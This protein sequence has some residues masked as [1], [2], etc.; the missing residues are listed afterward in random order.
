VE[1][2]RQTGNDQ[3]SL[4]YHHQFEFIDPS[5]LDLRR[6]IPPPEAAS[7][8]QNQ[9][10]QAQSFPP[11]QQTY[12]ELSEISPEPS[13]A[14]QY[15]PAALS[16][17]APRPEYQ[18]PNAFVPG[19]GPS[20]PQHTC[21]T[22]PRV[23]LHSG[24]LKKHMKAHTLPF[25]CAI[26]SCPRASRGFRYRKDV[27]RHTRSRHSETVPNAQRFYC[28]VRTCKYSAKG[29]PRLDLFKRHVKGQHPE[30]S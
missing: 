20:V 19:Q 17:A 10:S 22:C 23:F 29:F 11:S 4:L 2:F 15:T 26:P 1:S 18:D 14:Q 5:L 27:D 16:D 24:E 8:S 3:Q 13:P 21:D 9:Q 7:S 12:Q 30:A 25:K 28:P 6:H